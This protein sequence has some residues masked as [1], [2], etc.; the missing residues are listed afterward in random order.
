MVVAWEIIIKNRKL[1]EWVMIIYLGEKIVVWIIF[2]LTNYYNYHIFY[3]YWRIIK[4]NASWIC[5]IGAQVKPSIPSS[6]AKFFAIDNDDKLN[7][8][9]ATGAFALRSDFVETQA[10]VIFYPLLRTELDLENI[11]FI[12]ILFQYM[13]HHCLMWF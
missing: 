2:Y 11:F 8:R 3:F 5:L 6:E 13:L 4:P 10:I 7:S 9:Q 12:Q 1:I